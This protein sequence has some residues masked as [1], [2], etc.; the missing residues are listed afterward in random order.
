MVYDPVGVA[1]ALPLADLA[2]PE[3]DGLEAEFVSKA[4]ELA[5]VGDIEEEAESVVN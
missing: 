1:V 5:T 2:D 3:G 4:I